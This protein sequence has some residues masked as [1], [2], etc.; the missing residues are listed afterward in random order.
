MG[1]SIIQSKP[2][3]CRDEILNLRKENFPEWEA[4]K[5]DWYY[6]DNP[7]GPALC[8]VARGGTDDSVVG[9]TAVFPRRVSVGDNSL[10]GGITG[11]FGVSKKH[12]VLGPAVMLQKAGIAAYNEKSIDFLY[13]YPNKG[14]ELIQ[15]RVGYKIIGHPVRLV[16]MLASR[17]YIDGKIKSGIMSSITSS[18][19]DVG[20]KVFSRENLYRRDKD[21]QVDDSDSFD[22][23]FNDLWSKAS[24][25][26]PVLGERT[27][28][29]LNW[30]FSKCPF[31]DYKVFILSRKSSNQILGYIVY[32]ISGGR[33]YITDFLTENDDSV[34]SIILP[35]FLRFNKSRK[36]EAISFFYFGNDKITQCFKR[37]GFFERLDSTC[38]AVYAPDDME[39]SSILNERGNWYF[40]EADNDT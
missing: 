2:D 14:A 39:Y 23:R 33:L 24:N 30:R 36:L 25:Q 18:V 40:T 19:V 17:K 16:R 1:Y 8:W 4:K 15:K 7:Y 11:D 6:R 10:I 5:Y 22:N 27:A 31:R 26:Y 9:S 12:R 37:F 38:I 20:L 32:Y 21:L 29:F 13:G 3:E 34:I 28:D 35:E